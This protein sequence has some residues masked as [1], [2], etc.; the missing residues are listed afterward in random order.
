MLL[1][2]NYKITLLPL[3]AIHIGTGEELGPLDYF[4][5]KNTKGEIKYYRY[6]PN[7]IASAFDKEEQTVFEEAVDRDDM[8]ALRKLFKKNAVKQKAILYGAA[9]S[10]EVRKAYA[11]KLKKAGNQLLVHEMY[12]SGT[13]LFPVLP[14]SSLKGAMRTAILN[15]IAD[16]NGTV[17]VSDGSIR[18]K[19]ANRV[20][21]ALLGHDPKNLSTD[22]FRA[23]RISD[24][25]VEGDNTQLVLKVYNYRP[26]KTPQFL[27]KM[28]I[29]V[30]SI[31]GQLCGGDA[32]VTFSL[33]IDEAAM[34]KSNSTLNINKDMVV[35][36]CYE[37]YAKV[38]ND[39]YMQFYS[40]EEQIKPVVEQ[41][42]KYIQEE[43]D[44]NQNAS[45]IRVG[46]FS[47]RESM[48]LSKFTHKQGKS[49]MVAGYKGSFMPMGW[50]LMYV[51]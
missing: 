33:D 44:K 15:R 4:I 32:S 21:A 40:T 9:V 46:R 13:R 12:R 30:E 34:Q 24:G 39:E 49:R 7:K 31:R 38:L 8:I 26:H 16:D 43:I 11:E 3:T 45:L 36:S 2:A 6:F 20:E 1:M 27:D 51:Q 50:S 48:V 14:G 25:T 23:V 22:P 17:R 10:S 42:L 29:F 28:Q 37:F 35:D 19:N 5:G 18:E 47:Q 41:M